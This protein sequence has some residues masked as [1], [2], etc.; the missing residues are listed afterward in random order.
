GAIERPERHP[1][2]PAGIGGI[3]GGP[4]GVRIKRREH[5]FGARSGLKSSQN[6]FQ[7]VARARHRYWPLADPSF[8]A[9]LG[10]WRSRPQQAPR[11]GRRVQVLATVGRSRAGT[12]IRAG[13]LGAKPRSL[14]AWSKGGRQTAR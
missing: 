5:A 2:L 1:C 11:N 3:G 13:M 9:L 6:V 7:P 8:G 4:G 10:M 14:Q 12:T